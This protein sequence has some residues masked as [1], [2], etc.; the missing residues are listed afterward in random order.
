MSVDRDIEEVDTSDMLNVIQSLPDQIEKGF[1]TDVDFDG[2]GDI[3]VAGMG[4]SAIAGDILRVWLEA[5]GRFVHVV[6]DGTLPRWIGGEDALICIS[7]SGNTAETLACL[8]EGIERGCKILC[9][10]SGGKMEGICKSK[11]LAIAHVPGGMPPRGAIGYLFMALARAVA[12][13]QTL[14]S[15]TEAMIGSLKK[16]RERLMPESEE[17]VALEVAGQ[18]VDLVPLIYADERFL[19]VARRWKTQLNENSKK[20]AWIGCFPEINHNEIVGWDK[21]EGVDRF[22]A[23]VLRD[24]ETSGRMDATIEELKG[25]TMVIVIEAEGEN[26]LSRMFQELMIGDFVSYYCALLREVDPTP[27]EAIQRIKDA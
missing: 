27:V 11:G 4:G 15:E 23:I 6:R 7:H 20:H 18:M 17:N 8:Q 9:I 5:S 22:C 14:R 1:D 16:L 21:E 2:S 3:I 10:T 12:D 13:E 26:L 19:P 24:Q 25:R